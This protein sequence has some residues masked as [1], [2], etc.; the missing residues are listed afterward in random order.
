MYQVIHLWVQGICQT[1][2]QPKQNKRKQNNKSPLQLIRS[3]FIEKRLNYTPRKSLPS[4]PSGVIILFLVLFL[5]LSTIL[6]KVCNHTSG[7]LPI[8][9]LHALALIMTMFIPLRQAWPPHRGKCMVSIK[10][11]R[12]VK[13]YFINKSP[14][15]QKYSL[16]FPNPI[17]MIS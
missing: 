12:Q 13:S 8:P 10:Q 16:F 2:K 17:E 14:V 15:A 7:G 5:L 3:T 11:I 4:A 1:Q 9:Y 6:C